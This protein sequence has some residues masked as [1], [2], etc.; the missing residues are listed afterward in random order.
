[1]FLILGLTWSSG[2]IFPTLERALGEAL[3]HPGQDLSTV[4][5]LWPQQKTM[6]DLGEAGERPIGSLH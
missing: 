4:S 5:D 3:S 6:T 1:M 2:S